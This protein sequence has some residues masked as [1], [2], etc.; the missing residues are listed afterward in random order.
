MKKFKKILVIIILIPLYYIIFVWCLW[1][2]LFASFGIESLICNYKNNCI[3]VS[4]GGG[5]VKDIV[6]IIIP[7]ALIFFYIFYQIIQYITRKIE[8]KL[9]K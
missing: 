9:K 6:F 8:K 5:S 4:Y 3:Q 1:L 2:G 7:C